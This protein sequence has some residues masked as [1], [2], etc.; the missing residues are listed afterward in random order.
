MDDQYFSTP[1]LLIAIGAIIFIIAFFGCC[2]A[3]KENFCMTVTVL[4]LLYETIENEFNV[5]LLQFSTLLILIFVLE[6]AAGISGY[7]LRNQTGE[8]LTEKLTDSLQKYNASAD[9]PVTK[10]WDEIQTEVSNEV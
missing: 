4:M 10:M 1:N 2:G 3:V 8:Y 6:F 7:V 9:D 5:L